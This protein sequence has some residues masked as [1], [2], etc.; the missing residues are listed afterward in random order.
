MLEED[1]NILFS[2]ISEDLSLF[3]RRN[4]IHIL[5]L[6]SSIR[7]EVA[8]D[9]ITSWHLIALVNIP[10]VFLTIAEEDCVMLSKVIGHETL[11]NYKKLMFSLFV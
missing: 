8:N 3:V 11:V 4:K 2:E 7:S 9:T 10:E 6:M 1:Y 5:K